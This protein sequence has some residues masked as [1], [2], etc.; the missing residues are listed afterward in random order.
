MLKKLLNKNNLIIMVIVL[1]I[2]FLLI[3]ST[4][5][6]ANYPLSDYLK[7][8]VASWFVFIKYFCLAVMLIVFLAL[9]LKAAF[10]GL[11]EDR[12]NFKEMLIY[13][14]IGIILLSMLE[15]IIYFI[16]QVEQNMVSKLREIGIAIA[17]DSVVEQQ[18]SLYESVRTKA[19]E[20]RYTSG[21]FGLLMYM[22]L[23]YY[24]F[25]FFIIYVKRYLNVMILIL[26]SPIVVILY[27]FRRVFQ[28]KGGLIGRWVK[29]FLYNVFIQV[30]HAATY[31]ILVGFSLSLS[32][33]VLSFL[34]AVLTFLAFFFMFKLD[35]IIRKIF[36][37]VGGK[38]T[39]E[40]RDYV[41]IIKHPVES[42]NDAK[43]YVK[44]TLPQEIQSKKENLIE[45]FNP[46]NLSAKGVKFANDFANEAKETVR[47][48]DGS[49]MD[50]S[51]E[52]IRREQEKIDNPNLPQKVLNTIQGVAIGA[53]KLAIDGVETIAKKTKERLKKIQE[54]TKT[55]REELNQDF[56]MVKRF[57]KILRK[58]KVRKDIEEKAE[59]KD[60][61]EQ[62]PEEVLQGTVINLLPTEVEE[63]SM[64]KLEIEK[65]DLPDMVVT[66]YRI[67]GPAVFIYQNVGSGYMGM[68]VLA[69][70]KYE[71]RAID[72]KKVTD[73]K[74]IIRFPYG[75]LKSSKL[76]QKLKNDQKTFLKKKYK[77]KRFNR[78]SIITIT[79]SLNRRFVLNSEYLFNI[80][81]V[82]Q[83][84][85]NGDIK[86]RGNY[87]PN[88]KN[89]VRK[90]SIKYI[91]K[92][93][94]S[95]EHQNT[96]NID[97]ARYNPHDIRKEKVRVGNSTEQEGNIIYFKPIYERK[98]QAQ[99]TVQ[100]Y[101]DR[102]QDS[103]WA[104]LG[105]TAED[106]RGIQNQRITRS[107]QAVRQQTDAV[108]VLQQM[109]DMGA[110]LRINENL[111]IA[112]SDESIENSEGMIQ[113]DAQDEE[114]AIQE[115]IDSS[116]TDLAIKYDTS[117][118]NIDLMHN[119]E[120][121]D[122][123]INTL[124]EKG[125]VE[126]SEATDDKGKNDIIKSL[127][128]RKRKIL[129]ERNKN[130]VKGVMQKTAA[131]LLIQSVD[132]GDTVADKVAE[133]GT[134][135]KEAVK[136]SK[137]VDN[138]FVRA[139]ADSGYPELLNQIAKSAV[140][141]EA[142]RVK[143]ELMDQV[144]AA[145]DTT[146]EYVKT[147][148]E[149]YG[150]SIDDV[151]RKGEQI[152][153]NI[154]E[155]ADRFAEGVADTAEHM[156]K[157]AIDA[158][159]D[160]FKLSS[161]ND[162]EKG[163][164]KGEEYNS[165]DTFIFY[166]M[167]AVV[168]EGRYELPIGSRVYDAIKAAGGPTEEAD[169]T[170]ISYYDPIQNGETIYIPKRSDDDM[171]K[172]LEKCKPVVEKVIKD[173]IVENN[174]S[175][176]ESLKKLVH[177]KIILS[178]LKKSLSEENITE[179]QIESLY[180]ERLKELKY[181]RDGLKDATKDMKVV[182]TAKAT[183]KK[184]E[185]IEQDRKRQENGAKNSEE[186]S[187]DN[188][189]KRLHELSSSGS[190]A[191][192]IDS[193]SEGETME[194]HNQDVLMNELLMELEEQKEKVLVPAR[195]EGQQSENSGKYAARRHLTMNPDEMMDRILRRI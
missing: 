122:E 99:D 151:K 90:T 108:T 63:A 180:E 70:A 73:D 134:Q 144:Q 128:R 158:V 83:M 57:T 105:G 40:V 166:I 46:Q 13:W 106:V 186:I 72:R 64:I 124:T 118:E 76:D 155:G 47:A 15:E 183:A 132:T 152:K 175:N 36:N 77:F 123:L 171:E 169:L 66:A 137:L 192:D 35:G 80:Y 153:H 48:L 31:S 42:F 160:P 28:G 189:L 74:K 174:I 179:G 38:S 104:V 115:I 190:S 157:A 184:T 69:S 150:V 161:S 81:Q 39:V 14:I 145:V 8:T 119:T 59:N 18:N 140:R 172:I 163:R 102:V 16:I 45:S 178:K 53:V 164:R 10:S 87:A 139:I 149:L 121:Q 79:H 78:G 2:C 55:A 98:Q 177:K 24:T 136:D 30:V 133:V 116:I 60:E 22:V 21:M 113:L 5:Y 32:D 111:Y 101:H 176:I 110:A 109:T 23:V 148:Q 88:G 17:G 25:K 6:A 12:A 7:Q 67:Y 43:D 89:K 182:E 27:T 142:E 4:V 130:Y 168:N 165:D 56:E 181:I 33:N 86:V 112:F 71:Q 96:A 100:T 146:K 20:I 159:V 11:A 114:Y 117:L 107:V 44:E 61:K 138:K 143:Q 93:E 185:K 82:G 97:L 26:V 173:Y 147:G 187:L 65:N 54:A 19:Y 34:G 127:E 156:V 131:K 84:I 154:V 92:M 51:K 195:G 120:M 194:E 193:T 125:V 94:Q 188:A 3:P 129:R 191:S 141:S 75:Q 167:G 170:A 9:G 62:Q 91:A 29:E 85:A 162:R 126:Y 95:V 1:T 58:H 52:A 41:S 37:F 50:V 135:I 49:Q 103:S 68:S